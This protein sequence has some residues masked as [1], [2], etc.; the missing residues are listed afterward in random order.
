[1]KLRKSSKKGFTLIELIVVIAILGILAAILVP[2]ISG[3]IASANTATDVANAKMLY[4]AGMMVLATNTA[5]LP[6]TYTGTTGTPVPAIATYVSTWP[7]IKNTAANGTG[8]TVVVASSGVT[9]TTSTKTF[10]QAS[11]TFS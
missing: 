6:I 1:M 2:T 8:F 4:N 3:F 11:G 10:L 5:T 9:V 7:V